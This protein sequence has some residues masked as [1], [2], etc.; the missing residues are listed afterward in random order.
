[1]PLQCRDS[2][3]FGL[4]SCSSDIIKLKK[5]KKNH[6]LGSFLY[7]LLLS[8][9]NVYCDASIAS[10]LHHLVDDGSLETNCFVRVRNYSVV[11]VLT[12]LLLL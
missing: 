11:E 10:S 4:L 6:G 8:D 12:H 2:F 5:V 1:M 7:H 9:G 3:H